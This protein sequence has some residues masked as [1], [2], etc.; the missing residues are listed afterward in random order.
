MD[1]YDDPAISHSKLK[2]MARSPAHF[3]YAM[4]APNISSDALTMGSLVHAMVLEPH[5]VEGNFLRAEKIDRRTK[6]GKQAWLA[7]S[8]SERTVVK[9]EA[10]DTAEAMA[11]A[12]EACPE[13]VALVDEAVA[14]NKIEVEYFWDD[15]R[16]GVRR[17]S[18]VDALTES[19]IVDLKTTLD[20]S[21]SFSRSILKYSY[22]T[23]GA[24]YREAVRTRGGR[25]EDFKIIAVEKS[26]PYGVSIHRLGP[27]VL[28]WADETIRD[29]LETYR[30]CSSTNN[31][32]GFMGSVDFKIPSWAIES[33]NNGM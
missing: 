28:D 1:Y 32:P 10:W 5:T 26:A 3:R 2:V 11:A 31:W 7:L 16:Y 9:A 23:Q 4:D 8:E 33:E 30:S 25:Q 27:E 15:N 14:F 24:F 21:R 22:H 29:W 20:A 13:A 18:K 6:E 19:S 12:V 17:K